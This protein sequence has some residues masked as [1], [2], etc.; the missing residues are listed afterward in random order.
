MDLT[1]N[2]RQQLAA[3]ALQ[4][5]LERV[6]EQAQTPARSLG[7]ELAQ[8]RLIMLTKMPDRHH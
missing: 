2:F 4:R 8:A 6:S 1:G 5:Q 3:K 7:Q